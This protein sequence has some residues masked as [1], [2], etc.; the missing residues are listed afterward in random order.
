[1]LAELMPDEPEVLGLL[2]LLLLVQAREAARTAPDGMPVRLPDQD[3]SLW[4]GALIDEGQ[5]IVR[6]LLRRNTPGPYQI[7]AAINAV[8]SD[9]PTA[10]DTD[11]AQ[12]L[13]LY[14]QLAAFDTSPVVALNRAIAVAEVNGPAEAL[15]ALD[16]SPLDGYHLFHATRADLLQ[17]LGR[18][19]EALAAYDAALARV[20]NDAERRL[21]EQRRAAAD[22]TR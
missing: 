13:A 2:A 8:H 5:T 19:Q 1:L 10:S 15:S 21:L 18:T 4:E 16:A 9:A 6:A 20:V 22:R 11:W 14:D 7:Q 17:R 3:R 12:I